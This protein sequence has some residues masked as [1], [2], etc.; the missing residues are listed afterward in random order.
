MGFFGGAKKVVKQVNQER[1]NQKLKHAGQEVD[2]ETGLPA[3]VGAAFASVI[4]ARATISNDQRVKNFAE[5]FKSSGKQFVQNIGEAGAA[6]ADIFI[7]M[8]TREKDA[9]VKK[10]VEEVPIINVTL[11]HFRYNGTEMEAPTCAICIEDL[12]IGEEA[13]LLEC[14]HMFHKDCVLPW[15]AK[16]HNCPVCRF[17]LYKPK[18]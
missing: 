4:G 13:A 11:E 15:I 2:K 7:G 6:V 10:I 18:E 1:K 14:G 3:W 16:N 9:A 8:D 17:E 5:N 12:V